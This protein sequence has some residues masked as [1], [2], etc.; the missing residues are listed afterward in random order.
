MAQKV[1]VADPSNTSSQLITKG[2]IIPIAP[3]RMR[4][5]WYPQG[6][7][8]YVTDTQLRGTEMRDLVV[9][10]DFTFVRKRA[11]DG[12]VPVD[13]NTDSVIHVGMKLLAV[14]IGLLP[15]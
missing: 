15:I 13:Q 5:I 10:R 9:E 8:E 7:A 6:K 1:D 3:G 14:W 12:E 4:N 11:T 2:A